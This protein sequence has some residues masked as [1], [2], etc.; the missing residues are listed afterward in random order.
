MYSGVTT[1]MNGHNIQSMSLRVTFPGRVE[2][3]YDQLPYL[4]SFS[5]RSMF[6]SYIPYKYSL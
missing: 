5:F 6:I 1:W 2:S 3:R 4:S